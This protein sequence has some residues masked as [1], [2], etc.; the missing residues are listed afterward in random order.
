MARSM[1]L[2]RLSALVVFVSLGACDSQV[3][4]NPI[5]EGVD[6]IEIE[7]LRVEPSGY[8]VVSTDTSNNS[9]NVFLVEGFDLFG[10]SAGA[11]PIGVDVGPLV[12]SKSRASLA[13]T[14]DGGYVLFG[15]APAEPFPSQTSQMYLA[16]LD[17]TGGVQWY[18]PV[19]EPRER[20][21]EGAVQEL[22]GGGY[23]AQFW[24]EIDPGSGDAVT[25]VAR[26]DANGD[27]VWMKD[28]EP[29]P[30]SN[31]G[32]RALSDGTFAYTTRVPDAETLDDVEL[33]KLDALGDELWRQRHHFED[34][35]VRA[36]APPVAT[37]D[38]GFLLAGSDYGQFTDG[39]HRAWM[40]KTDASG[41]A[42]WVRHFGGDVRTEGGNPVEAADGGY[43]MRITRTIQ[44]HPF[45]GI[46]HTDANGDAPW[47]QVYGTPSCAQSRGILRLAN[48]GGF[49]LATQPD[50]S[51]NL[52][53][54][55]IKTDSLGNAPAAPADCIEP[56]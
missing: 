12:E 2:M 19:F 13:P 21:I 10:N 48:D 31:L 33:V 17:A 50:V 9:A 30:G 38:G 8:T 5:A 28:L 55:L 53:A 34:L 49:V 35:D 24:E 46:V 6:E 26:F 39:A 25:H 4:F 18:T 36:V 41:V 1:V 14:S 51:S 43:A 20:F 37:S 52:A 56:I 22:P 7:T 54:Y 44:S 16:K 40:S 11:S 32:L 3:F 15:L 42:Q 47:T 29:R 23:A 27:Q 45:V